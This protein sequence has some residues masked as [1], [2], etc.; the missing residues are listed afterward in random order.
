MKLGLNEYYDH[1]ANTHT[2]DGAMAAWKY[3]SVALRPQSVLDVGCG[4]G[5]WMRAMETDGILDVV[6]LDGVPPDKS[7]FLGDPNRFQQAD[8]RRPFDLQRRFDLVICLEVAEHLPQICAAQLVGSM[9]RHGDTI[10]FAA[11]APTQ[12]GQHHI[13]CQWPHYWQEH[14]N[15]Q[16][17]VCSDEVRVAMWEDPHVEPWY[18]Q[19][20]FIARRDASNAGS[21]PRLRSLIHPAMLPF[22]GSS[23]SNIH[24]L[25]ISYSSGN[26]MSYRGYLRAALKAFARGWGTKHQ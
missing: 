26:E 14:F 19:N 4:R 12:G 24:S 11:A 7:E 5:T 9:C 16:G 25:R 21:E 2:V 10:A 20:M 6:G 18:R 13:N 23:E 8:L 3:L 15:Q 22:M 17:F 1:A